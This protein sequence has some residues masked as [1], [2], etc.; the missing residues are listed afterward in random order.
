MATTTDII[1]VHGISY[2]KT[3]D[4]TYKYKLVKTYDHSSPITIRPRENIDHSHMA[5]TVAG[6]LTVKER[7]AWDGPSGPTWDTPTFMRGSLVHDAL[8]Q[9]LR[10]TL[11]AAE[12]HERNREGADKLLRQVCREDGMNPFRAWYVF[13]AVRLF[14]GSAARPKS[15]S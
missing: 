4:P 6:M 10:E 12:E 15:R 1:T 3:A 7:Y 2:R 8:Y 13:W 5:L 9:I 11:L 14:A